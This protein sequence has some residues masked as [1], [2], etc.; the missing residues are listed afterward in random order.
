M[1]TTM[2]RWSETDVLALDKVQRRLQ[3]LFPERNISRPEVLKALVAAEASGLTLVQAMGQRE[4][5]S[6]DTLPPTSGEREGT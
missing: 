3:D 6:R 4:L 1:R 2:I 5:A